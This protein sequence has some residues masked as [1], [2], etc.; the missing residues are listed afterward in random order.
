MLKYTQTFNL[1]QKNRIQLLSF[2]YK[3]KKLD[4]SCLNSHFLVGSEAIKITLQKPKFTISNGWNRQGRWVE[5]VLTIAM[6][7]RSV[8]A[9]RRLWLILGKSSSTACI[10]RGVMGLC[11]NPMK[12]LL[13]QRMLVEIHNKNSIT[14]KEKQ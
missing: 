1:C 3:L 2:Y 14:F 11:S 12:I 7:S 8:S 5:S 4:L 10:S 13:G 6:A 9:A